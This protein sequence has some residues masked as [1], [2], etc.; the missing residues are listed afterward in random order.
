MFLL[1][2]IKEHILFKLEDGNNERSLNESIHSSLM[3][4]KTHLTCKWVDS[5]RGIMKALQSQQLPDDNKTYEKSNNE[6]AISN[7]KG[8]SSL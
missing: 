7:I 3:G 5:V 1:W 6:A 4:M 2:S 8:N